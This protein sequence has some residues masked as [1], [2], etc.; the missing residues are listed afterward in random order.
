MVRE[1]G[2]KPAFVLALEHLVRMADDLRCFEGVACHRCGGT[3]RYKSSR[4]CVVCAKWQA[5]AVTARRRAQR[6]VE[7]LAALRRVGL[8]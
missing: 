5:R 1:K 3:R 6:Q 7:R 4:G 2:G 8:R